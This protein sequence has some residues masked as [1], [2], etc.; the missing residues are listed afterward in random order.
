M[1]PL[2]AWAAVAQVG[3]D[4]DVVRLVERLGLPIAILLMLVMRKGIEPSFV[5]DREKERADRCEVRSEKLADLYNERMLPAITSQT[6][7]NLD[8][9]RA[10]A[11]LT[12]ENREQ[13]TLI[14]VLLAKIEVTG[15]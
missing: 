8:A 3:G 15:K 5:G 6:Q 14:R 4:L 12:M 11:D 13:A 10:L 1:A 2:F 9:T 7:A